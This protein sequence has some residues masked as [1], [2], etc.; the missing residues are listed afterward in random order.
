MSP[1]EPWIARSYSEEFRR[2]AVEIARLRASRS[3][4]IAAEAALGG[5]LHPS[6]CQAAPEHQCVFA[7]A[8]AS[9]RDLEDSRAYNIRGFGVDDPTPEAHHPVKTGQV[10]ETRNA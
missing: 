2:R 1:D 4:K 10:R 5:G 8:P 9:D 7:R 6:L 3:G